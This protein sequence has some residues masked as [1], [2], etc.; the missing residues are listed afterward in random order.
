MLEVKRHGNSF[1]ILGGAEEAPFSGPNPEEFSLHRQRVIAT[2]HG[3]DLEATAYLFAGARDLLTVLK[4]LRKWHQEE[5]HS[6][7]LLDAR[8]DLAIANAEGA[9]R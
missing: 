8:V 9:G 3:A 7:P 6:D 2:V 5:Y 4:Q 1:S